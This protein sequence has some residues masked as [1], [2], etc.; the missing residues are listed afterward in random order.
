MLILILIDVQYLQNVVFS[1]KN[2]SN[3]SNHS[4]SDSPH[5]I[6]KVNLAKFSIPAPYE[7]IWKTLT[8]IIK[9]DE[10]NLYFSGELN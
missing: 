3:F 4:S 1:I 6:K 5:P 9:K 7:S 2:G 8:L 10:I